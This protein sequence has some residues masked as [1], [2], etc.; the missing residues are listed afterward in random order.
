VDTLDRHTMAGVFETEDG[1]QYDIDDLERKEKCDFCGK[2]GEVPDEDG[3]LDGQLPSI[4]GEGYAGDRGAAC[5]ECLINGLDEE[6]LN[7]V[8]GSQEEIVQEMEEETVELS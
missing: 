6:Q 3:F 1:T 5:R 2:L 7:E 8:I 4:S